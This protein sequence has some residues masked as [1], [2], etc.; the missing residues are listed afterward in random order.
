M[1]WITKRWWWMEGARNFS[2]LERIQTVSCRAHLASSLVGNG[3]KL[4]AWV[5][6]LGDLKLPI[7]LH[8]VLAGDTGGCE[9]LLFL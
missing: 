9:V 1:G 7:H 8:L 4:S 5:K 6:F 3:G 2:L